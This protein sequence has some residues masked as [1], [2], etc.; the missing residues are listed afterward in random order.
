M[1]WGAAE[2]EALG[3]LGEG[4][5]PVLLKLGKDLSVDGIH[6]DDP[7]SPRTPNVENFGKHIR[8]L[9]PI[10]PARALHCG[11]RTGEQAPRAAGARPRNVAADL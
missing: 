9:S 6:T 1:A 7:C 8:R 3:E 5:S 11:K 4:H 10:P 2:T